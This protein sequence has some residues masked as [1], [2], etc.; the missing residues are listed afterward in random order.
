MVTVWVRML[1]SEDGTMKSNTDEVEV[2]VTGNNISALKRALFPMYNH[3][4]LSKTQLYTPPSSAGGGGNWERKDPHT[5][6]V[7]GKTYGYFPVEEGKLSLVSYRYDFL[8]AW[9]LLA[10]FV[11]Q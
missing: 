2:N 8:V 7:V 6:L 11:L 5:A 3:I 1:Q 10:L 4:M 9:T